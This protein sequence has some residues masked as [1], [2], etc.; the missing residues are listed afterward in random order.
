MTLKMHDYE[1]PHRQI[2]FDLTTG[3]HITQVALV[4]LYFKVKSCL[5][6]QYSLPTRLVL[7][8]P[9]SDL[10][11]FDN[12]LLLLLAAGNLAMQCKVKSVLD[13]GQNAKVV[14]RSRKK[15]F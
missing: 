9:V 14:V 5:R 2:D 11:T 12:N 4:K 10:P 15:T 3:N 13:L 1:D 7:F 6:C 8:S